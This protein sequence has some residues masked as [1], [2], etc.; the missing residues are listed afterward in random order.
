MKKEDLIDAIGGLDNSIVEKT[1]KKMTRKV[2]PTNVV[3]GVVSTVMVLALLIPTTKLIM[4]NRDK[5]TYSAASRMA[6]FEPSDSTN[7]SPC[8]YDESLHQYLVSIG[9]EDEWTLCPDEPFIEID[10]IVSVDQ[11]FV[12][13]K[14]LVS[15]S[16]IEEVTGYVESKAG[17]TIREGDYIWIQEYDGRLFGIPCGGDYGD[18]EW[19]VSFYEYTF[20]CNHT[21]E[22]VVADRGVLKRASGANPEYYISAEEAY[23]LFLKI[24]EFNEFQGIQK[25]VEVL[26]CDAD[27]VTSVYNSFVKDEKVIF[28]VIP[29][30]IRG[31]D[32]F[33]FMVD[34]GRF[35]LMGN[36]GSINYG[37]YDEKV[38]QV[39]TAELNGDGIADVCLGFIDGSVAICEGKTMAEIKIFKDNEYRYGLTV[40]DGILQITQSKQSE[41]YMLRK[42]TFV[43]NGNAPDVKWGEWKTY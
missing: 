39:I 40:S 18:T 14:S 11:L 29:Q 42:G 21:F 7:T 33:S 6:E 23:G 37:C 26:F 32:D 1:A 4:L 9:V 24:S 27:Q 25:N 22:F 30:K 41:N 13:G 12:C 38:N 43:M 2:D 8:D 31:Y 28:K 36:G 34:G 5:L 10:Y 16:A 35:F 20:K 15:D 19:S 3:L 17:I